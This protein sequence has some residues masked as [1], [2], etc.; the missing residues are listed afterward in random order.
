MPNESPSATGVLTACC[1]PPKGVT[2]GG[3]FAACTP[4][5][6]LTSTASTKASAPPLPGQSGSESSG[7]PILAFNLNHVYSRRLVV[8]SSEC[9]G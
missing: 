6:S 1:S 7:K 5:P 4:V 3:T 2:A 9:Y 8:F